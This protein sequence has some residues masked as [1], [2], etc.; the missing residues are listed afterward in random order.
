[1]PQLPECVLEIV[2]KGFEE[3]KNQLTRSN[4]KVIGGVDSLEPYYEN[5]A[6]VVMPILYGDGMKVK[7]AEAMMYG[8]VIF[9]SE[10]ALE[11]IVLRSSK[12]FS[13]VQRQRNLFEKLEKTYC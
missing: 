8:K 9:A 12:A 6:A 3:L 10:E 7:T 5:A 4:V 2:G 13:A 11:G 1:M